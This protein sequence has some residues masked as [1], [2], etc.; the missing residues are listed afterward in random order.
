MMSRATVWATAAGILVG[1]AVALIAQRS[2]APSYAAPP[3]QADAPDAFQ[4]LKADVA[5]LKG[6]VPDQSHSMSDVAYHFT[7]LYFAGT[8]ENWPLAQF[9]SDETHSHLRWAVRIIP[10]R[11]DKAGRDVDLD[12]ILTALEQTSLKDLDSAIKAKD[13]AKFIDAYKAQMTNCMAC[14]K[15]ASKEFI[16]LRI[17]E[18]PEAQIVEFAPE[19]VST[20]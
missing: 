3:P 4:A 12:G 14:H 5:K 10:M 6:M 20:P 17:P 13:K 16:R 9:Y 2:I 1:M 19:P 8:S 7:N 11:K 18:H 15:A